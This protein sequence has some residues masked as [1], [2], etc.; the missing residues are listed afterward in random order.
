MK[1]IF[2]LLV[3]GASSAFAAVAT[4]EVP[5]SQSDLK[6]F[7]V[8]RMYDV[9]LALDGSMSWLRVDLFGATLNFSDLTTRLHGP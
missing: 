1:S 7:S 3:L 2:L 9:H 6:S 4:Y 8:F 5:T